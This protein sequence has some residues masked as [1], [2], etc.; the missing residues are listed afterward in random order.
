MTSS[1]SP[2][3]EA[4][5]RAGLYS[6]P[7]IVGWTIDPDLVWHGGQWCTRWHVFIQMPTGEVAEVELYDVFAQ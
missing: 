7:Q 2:E 5:R 3:G 1:A 4:G 6:F